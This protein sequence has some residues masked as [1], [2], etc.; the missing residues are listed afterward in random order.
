MKMKQKMLITFAT[1]AAV[2]CLFV[3]SAFANDVQQTNG[4]VNMRI[5]PGTQYEKICVVPVGS[6]V[7]IIQNDNGWS[8]VEYNNTQ[9]WI[10]TKYLGG[11]APAPNNNYVSNSYND[12]PIQDH[13]VTA[14]VNLRSGP[15]TNYGAYIV[16]PAGS[17]IGVDSYSN[18]WAHSYYGNYEGYISTSYVSGLGG[19]TYTAPTNNYNYN[20]NSGTT[21]YNGNNYAN[22][23]DYRY[24]AATYPDLVAVLGTDP[25]ALIAHFV[26]SGMNEGRQG[27]SSFNVY[28]YRNEHPDLSSQFGDNLRMYYLYACGIPFTF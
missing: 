22:V 23:Y 4:N 6:S 10:A 11:Y 25:N 15:G 7:Y 21:W 1:M 16:V 18:G 24:Y 19:Y 28:S 3:T 17:V 20:N 12:N 13:T 2:F 9:G 5:G 8:N 26:N 14:D 27:I